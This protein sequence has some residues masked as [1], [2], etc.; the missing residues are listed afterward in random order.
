MPSWLPKA[1]EGI[2]QKAKDAVDRNKYKDED[3]YYAVVTTVYKQ[4][5]GHIEAFNKKLVEKFA[6]EYKKELKEGYTVDDIKGF[7]KKFIKSPF[8]VGVI[9]YLVYNIL[10]ESNTTKED[11]KQT[12]LLRYYV[13]DFNSVVSKYGFEVDDENDYLWIHSNNSDLN[14]KVY[15][16]P[17]NYKM[18]V[19]KGNSIKSTKTDNIQRILKDIEMIIYQ[20]R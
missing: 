1:D 16:V 17:F 8:K 20:N 19:L 18:L 3:S 13:G 6:E 10:K 12:K 4:M 7:L 5:G 2:W 15:E 11:F 14:F 9:A